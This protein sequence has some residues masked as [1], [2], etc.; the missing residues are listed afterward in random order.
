MFNGCGDNDL[1]FDSD[2]ASGTHKSTQC[3]VRISAD[4]HHPE[5][6]CMIDIRASNTTLIHWMPSAIMLGNT[7][8]SPSAHFVHA[9][10]AFQ[11]KVE[12]RPPD[13]SVYLDP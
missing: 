13:A 10:P 9:D 7:E 12:H 3:L 6:S 2:K 1:Q 11:W 8:T 5:L 4:H